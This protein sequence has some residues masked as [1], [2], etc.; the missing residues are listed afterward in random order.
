MLDRQAVGLTLA[1][2]AGLFDTAGMLSYSW[3]YSQQIRTRFLAWNL[4]WYLNQ[5]YTKSNKS[6]ASFCLK[7]FLKLI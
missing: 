2:R 5:E 6:G 4:Q 7:A 3:A 1:F